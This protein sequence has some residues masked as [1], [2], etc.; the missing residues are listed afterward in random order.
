MTIDTTAARQLL[1]SEL[2]LEGF[3]ETEQQE[4]IDM[5]EENIVIKINNDIFGM[6]D[7]K[8]KGEFIL[9]AQE[10]NNEQVGIFLKERIA[11]FDGLIKRAAQY[12]IKDFK[13]AT[14]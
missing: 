13:T 8:E 7:E 9:L 1:V 3:T 4:I 12:I 10:P 5:L 14:S 2:K 6:L 11:D